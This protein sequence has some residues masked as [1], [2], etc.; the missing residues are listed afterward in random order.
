M[1]DPN[2]ETDRARRKRLRSARPTSARLVVV[3]AFT[4]LVVLVGYLGWSVRENNRLLRTHHQQEQGMCR[5]FQAVGHFP[6][7]DV[8]SSAGRT[9]VTSA[10]DAARILECPEDATTDMHA[11]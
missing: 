8:Q 11:K 9:I 1:T 3:S 10:A 7:A 2:G 4:A 5:F 6:L